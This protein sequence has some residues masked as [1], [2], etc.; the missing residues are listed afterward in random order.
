MA[1]KNNWNEITSLSPCVY[2]EALPPGCSV[3]FGGTESPKAQ[4]HKLFTASKTLCY[5]AKQIEIKSN[6]TLIMVDFP[7][8]SYS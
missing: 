6:M 7:Q 3:A 8:P 4:I 2:A 1:A 5:S